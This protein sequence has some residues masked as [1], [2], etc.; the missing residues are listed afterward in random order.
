MADGSLG[1]EVGECTGRPVGKKRYDE[2]C[3]L[4]VDPKDAPELQTWERQAITFAPELVRELA[5]DHDIVLAIVF[6][7]TWTG[8]QL[9]ADD[10]M[11]RS[12]MYRP[13]DCR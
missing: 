7:R 1:F 2:A 6:T 13:Y 10:D 12:I 11:S 5:D 3:V 8:A 4:R 9:Y